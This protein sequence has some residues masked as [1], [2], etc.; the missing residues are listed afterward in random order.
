[1]NTEKAKRRYAVPERYILD[2]EEPLRKIRHQISEMEEWFDRDPD[3]ARNEIK[4]LEE[5]ENRLGREIYSNLTSWQKVQIAR[6]PRRPHT[7]DYVSMMMADFIELHGDRTTGDDPAMVAGFGKLDDITVAVIGQQKGN[8]NETIISRNFGMPSPE[9]YRKALRI[10]KLAEKFSRPVLSFIDTPGAFPGIEAE[11]H[12]QGE[13][14]ARNLTEM[15][16]LRVPVIVTIIGEGGSG[17]ALGIGVG[18]RI[19]MLENAWYSV[20]APESCS[21]ILMKNTDKKERLAESLKLTA[22]ELKKLGIVDYII[23]EPLGGA[24]NDPQKVAAALKTE[25]LTILPELMHIPGNDIID[26][27]IRKYKAMGRWSE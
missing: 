17:G 18:D 11:E 27:R 2:F 4:R 7:L 14:I 10:M 19:L 24:H 23:K 15:S 9:G 21:M 13:A 8:D 12:G 16:R 26:A 20:I 25:L 5:Q 1:M 3:Y 6:H 22:V